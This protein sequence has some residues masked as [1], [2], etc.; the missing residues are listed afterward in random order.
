MRVRL[1]AFPRHR[2]LLYSSTRLARAGF[3]VA[4]LAMWQSP[5]VAGPVTPVDV[6]ALPPA[7]PADHPLPM[8]AEGE[9]IADCNDCHTTPKYRPTAQVLRDD[10]SRCHSTAVA[11]LTPV[12]HIQTRDRA[13]GGGIRPDPVLAKD[14]AT[15]TRD[16]VHVPGG[17]F[18]LGDDSR[19][20]DEGPMQEWTVD[21]FW[22]DRLEVTN[23]DYHRYTVATGRPAPSHWKGSLPPD[24][25]GSH[26]VTYVSWYDARDY[27]AWRGKRLPTEFEWEKAAR[28]T[29]GLKFPWGDIFD[30]KLGN[31]PQ[32][33]IGHTTPVGSFPKGAS[34]YGAMDMAGNVWEWTDSWYRPYPGNQ[35]SNPNY[36]EVYRIVRGGSWYDCE[37]Y[38]CGIS[39]PTF[40]RGFFIPNTQN[41]T[42][43][44][45]CAVAPPAG[46]SGSVRPKKP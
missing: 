16:M 1:L 6:S 8:N 20:P 26:P 22:L 14:F 2:G 29:D 35:R 3:A 12:N 7:L 37:F 23:D 30:A 19:H 28:G 21:E 13:K 32:S 10:C 9:I 24:A 44:F 15:V 39:A 4:L 45:R 31:S 17:P 25:I 40:N 36:G 5:A 42:F 11:G 43:G 46:A 33:G 27:C 34:P 38:K 41:D 18:V